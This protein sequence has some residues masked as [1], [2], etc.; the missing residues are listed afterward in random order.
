MEITGPTMMIFQK[1][2]SLCF[3]L[4]DGRELKAGKTLR[5]QR[6][7]IYQVSEKPSLYEFFAYCLTPFG[8]QTGPLLEFRLWSYL[9]DAPLRHRV[10]ADSQ[11]RSLS[12]RYLL[13]SLLHA[14]FEL[15]LG[16]YVT[17]RLYLTDFYISMPWFVKVVLMYV[18]ANAAAARYY[19]V[20]HAVNASVIEL[21][22]LSSGFAT[23]DDFSQYTLLW[24]LE[25]LS[26]SEWCQRWNHST[27]VFW[28]N[29]LYLRM[30]DAGMGWTIANGV[31][32]LF[33]SSWHGFKAAYYMILFETLIGMIVDVRLSKVF[34]VTHEDVL[35]KR[36]VKAGW[37][38]VVM[39]SAASGWW[40]G[41]YEWY[42]RIHNSHYWAPVWINLLLW[43]F[44]RVFP[45]RRPKTE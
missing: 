6:F 5:H 31:V 28:K 17:Y 18:V 30:L 20:W 45:L 44:L 32:F 16:K 40:T 19:V 1:V 33:S 36:T 22:L 27:H 38:S 7:Y 24:V 26:I 43:V 29:Y 15:T 37:V 41:T 13:Y 35:W 34:P 8:G 11:D 2:I 23:E 10:A 4:V 42:M 39:L 25:S 9:M 14:G 3:N 12:L 21:G